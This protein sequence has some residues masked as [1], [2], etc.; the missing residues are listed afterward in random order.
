VSVPQRLEPSRTGTF[1]GGGGTEIW[2]Q[3]WPTVEPRADVVLAHGAG[4]H[5]ARYG[6][7]A[8]ALSERGYSV[9]A[10]DHRGHGNSAGPRALI[11]SLERAVADIHTLVGIATGEAAERRPYLL[12]HSMGGLLAIAY[13]LRHQEAIAGLIL[14][15]PAAALETA[16]PITRIV[17]AALS[18]VTPKLGVFTVDPNGVSR[19]PD[20]VRDYEDDPQVFH[21]KLPVRTVAELATEIAAL[22]DRAPE[23]TLPVLL[24]YGTAD[25]IVPPSGSVMLSER[26]ASTDLTTTPYDGLYHEILNEPERDQVIAEL[27]AWLD[28]HTG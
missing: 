2:W 24:M 13:A 7:V 27:L 22:S 20:V 9:W 8:R 4:E 18:R 14:S 19:D 10:L 1:A 25:P 15:A 26:I 6:H 3:A 11:D 21:G 17:S 5:S 28:A 23:I 12:G 16:S